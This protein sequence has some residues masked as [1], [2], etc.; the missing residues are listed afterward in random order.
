MGL[1]LR[2]KPA[3]RQPL[4]LSEPGGWDTW[5]F[6]RTDVYSATIAGVSHCS[7]NF[8]LVPPGA[9]TSPGTALSM[10]FTFGAVIWGH[11]LWHPHL[12][13][14]SKKERTGTTTADLC[15]SY[16]SEAATL[17]GRGF[18]LQKPS[19]KRGEKVEENKALYGSNLE[20]EPK[21]AWRLL[22]VTF[23]VCFVPWPPRALLELGN[24]S[25]CGADVNFPVAKSLPSGAPGGGPKV[26][27][28]P[29]HRTGVRG[30]GGS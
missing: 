1:S 17:L 15:I 2:R 3:T 5:Q 29:Q 24:T 21:L 20:M 25:S 6:P 27:P 10:R 9:L 16:K 23:F 11:T 26:V 4:R 7:T 30:P 8:H 13:N 14:P 19:R 28:A 12:P 18:S 22:K